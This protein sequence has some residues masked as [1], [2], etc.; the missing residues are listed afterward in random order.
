MARI[1]DAVTR[2]LRV[3]LRAGLMDQPKPSRASTRG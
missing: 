1:D 3:K 2:I